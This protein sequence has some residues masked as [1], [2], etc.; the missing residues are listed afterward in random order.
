M[1]FLELSH[2]SGDPDIKVADRSLAEYRGVLPED[3][4]ASMLIAWRPRKFE[5]NSFD[6]VVESIWGSGDVGEPGSRE[7]TVFLFVHTAAYAYSR[8]DPVRP[9][10]NA[11]PPLSPPKP[12][13]SADLFFG[14]YGELSDSDTN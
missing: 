2:E 13:S 14:P 11:E 12:A 4:C 8:P 10:F 9:S 1:D 3:L 7:H 5:I 6:D